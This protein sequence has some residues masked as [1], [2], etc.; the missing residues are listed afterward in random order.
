MLAL[1]RPTVGRYEEST[2]E[3]HSGTFYS[4][5]LPEYSGESWG[6]PIEVPGRDCYIRA[7][8]KGCQAYRPVTLSMAC[9]GPHG[10]DLANSTVVFGSVE[11]CAST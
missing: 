1:A 4:L 6:W 7:W 8:H 3:V 11:S 5:K 10:V 2:L 9:V